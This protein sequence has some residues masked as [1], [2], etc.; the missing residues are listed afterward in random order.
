MHH[1][2][3]DKYARGT[4]AI[5]GL[6]AR[7]KVLFSFAFI[8]FIASL[9]ASGFE[10]YLACLTLIAVCLIA[11]RIP[12][13]YLLTRS[14]V[15]I[16]FAG[17][18]AISYMLTRTGG[19]TYWHSGPF[20]ITSEGLID[21]SHLLARS[22]LAVSCMIILVNT[23]PFDQILKAFRTFRLH[24]I[25]IMLLSFFYRYLYLLWDESER[26]QRARNLRYF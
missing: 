5:H 11:A 10:F 7:V 24:S 14:I 18:A 13:V 4:T 26:M 1:S 25:L 3:L 12:T 8:I 16:P 22:W 15:V 23:T 21:A 20:A 19:T 9:R 2:Y 17:F 6:D